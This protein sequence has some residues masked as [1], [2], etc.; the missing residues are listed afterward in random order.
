M[1]A[2]MQKA[3]AT[4]LPEIAAAAADFSIPEEHEVL[5]QKANSLREWMTNHQGFLATF[6]GTA[7]IEHFTLDACSLSLLPHEIGQLR[8]LR[9]LNL[10]DN[11]LIVLSSEIRQLQALG[12]LLLSHNRLTTLPPEIGQLPA[13]YAL[14]LDH[15]RL[16]AL[17]REMVQLHELKILSLTGNGFTARPVWPFQPTCRQHWD[18]IKWTTIPLPFFNPHIR[19]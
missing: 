14:W 19:M 8:A 2:G 10:Q 12:C 9:N 16:T 17:P 4:P 15:N 11:S 1:F 13:M 3:I 18:G 6:R 7:I 5:L